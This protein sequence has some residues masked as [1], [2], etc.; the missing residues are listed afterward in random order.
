M[1]IHEGVVVDMLYF[2]AEV[3]QVRQRAHLVK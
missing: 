1:Y 3:K 2:S